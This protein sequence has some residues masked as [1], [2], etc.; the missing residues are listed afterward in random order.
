MKKVGVIGGTGYVGIV[1]A[2]G[3]AEIG[4]EVHAVDLNRKAVAELEKGIMPIYEEGLAPLVAGNMKDGRLF[5]HTELGP[6]VEA[7]DI[8]FVA[9]GTPATPSGEADL[10]Q[11]IN[12]AEEL[13]RQMTGYKIIVIKSTVPVGTFE[14]FN[15]IL[16]NYGKQAG[17]D[18]DL[19]SNPE[20]LREGSAVY[21]FFNPDRIVV[22]AER[23]ETG[24]L[25]GELFEPFQAPIIY[26]TIRNAQIIKYAS[27][28]FLATRLSFI[29][30]IAQ[31]C[32]RTGAD[33]T[34]VAHGMGLDK[35]IGNHYLNAGIGFGGPCLI[36]DLKAL[37]KIAENFDYDPRFL[38]AV[39][40]KNQHQTKSVVAKVKNALGGLL[41]YKKVGVLGLT[42]KPD[43]DDVR[44]SLAVE[45]INS[46]IG[47]GALVKAYDPQGATEAQKLLPAIQIC[48][49]I[50]QAV[51]GI[52]LLLINLTDVKSKMRGKHIVDGVNILNSR[53]AVT[54]GFNYQGIG[55][56]GKKSI[57]NENGQS[58]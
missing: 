22:G 35:R 48:Q 32:E 42:F 25:V 18:F 7:S 41:H 3:L 55:K 54:A 28:V 6:V 5:F 24:Q 36:K 47:S 31:I 39:Y 14:L 44:T 2:V 1:T 11:I 27:N 10:T 16:S 51:E 40:E 49:D 37:I 8:I 52:D 50:N 9:V 33:V 38:R 57:F 46:L 23:E 20:F 53:D 4:N 45:I 56:A 17:I 12:V 29:N 30:E 43:T 13:A 34:E 19:V 26:T 21:D 58:M 15:D